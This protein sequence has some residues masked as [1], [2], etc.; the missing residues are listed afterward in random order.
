M[1]GRCYSIAFTEAGYSLNTATLLIPLAL[2]FFHR[3]LSPSN[4]PDYVLIMFVH[5]LSPLNYKLFED[6]T[7]FVYFINQLPRT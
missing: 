1:A 3:I 4:M 7:F 5:Y 2:V 6:E